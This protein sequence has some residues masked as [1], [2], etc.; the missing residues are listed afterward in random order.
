ME[1]QGVRF[2]MLASAELDRSIAFYRD[3][4]GLP[5]TA[6][7]EDFAFFDCYGIVLALSGQLARGRPESGTATE[8]VFGVPSVK[9]AFDELRAS[10]VE[11][12]NAPRAVN[13][14]AWAVNLNDPDGHLLSLYGR[15]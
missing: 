13:D 9:D 5:L 7:F 8:I 15:A 1:I 11:F 12:I 2:V 3:R 6:R 14:E 4:L 10:G